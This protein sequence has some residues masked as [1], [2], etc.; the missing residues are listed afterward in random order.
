M[1]NSIRP[2]GTGPGMF[3]VNGDRVRVIVAI[4]GYGSGQWEFLYGSEELA[5]AACQQLR[6]SLSS[7]DDVAVL[8]K[9]EYCLGHLAQYVMSFRPSNGLFSGYRNASLVFDGDQGLQEEWVDG[10]RAVHIEDI[11]QRDGLEW[12]PTG[13]KIQFVTRLGKMQS[14]ILRI[15]ALSQSRSPG[16]IRDPRS[17]YDWLAELVSLR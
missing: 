1:A 10:R 15:P 17:P 2:F 6:D 14:E 3:G 11:G 16:F 9:R 7:D 8:L 5:T 4:P 12:S 13:Q